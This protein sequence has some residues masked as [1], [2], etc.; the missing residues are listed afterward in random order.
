MCVDAIVLIVIVEMDDVKRLKVYMVTID[1]NIPQGLKDAES[2][3][4][5]AVP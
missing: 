1:N 5:H 2:K 4:G 3:N